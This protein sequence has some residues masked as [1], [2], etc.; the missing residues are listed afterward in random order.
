M[1]TNKFIKNCGV[2]TLI[3]FLTLFQTITAECAYSRTTGRFPAQDTQAPTSPKELKAAN[4]TFT[5]VVLSWQSAADNVGIKGYE[6]YCN[7]R[8][9]ASTTATVYE[10]K[11]LSPGAAYL[12]YVKAYDKAGNYSPQSSS[13]LV[14]TQADKTAPSTPSGLKASFISETEVNLIW[15]PSSDNV[16]VRG[17]DIMRNGVKIGTT[18]KTNYSNKA[19]TPDKSYIYSV[20]ASDVSGNLSNS[21]ISLTVTTP[22]DSQAP[23]A[24]AGL[25]IA[26]IKDA[27]VSLEWTASAD[28]SKIAGYQIYCNGVVIATAAGTSRIVKSPFNQGFDTYFIRSYD[29][30]GNLS[31]G[32]NIVTVN[33]AS[34]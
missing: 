31:A 5:S 14:N 27:A 18:S 11:A 8:K 3:L 15:T 34:E 29:I 1:K 7:G 13:I 21:S 25:K 16:K 28:N 33:I 12:F 24:P 17:Y 9:V 30:A 6:L 22:K 23:T 26:A 20:R 19:L 4:A 2:I 32:S 10:Y